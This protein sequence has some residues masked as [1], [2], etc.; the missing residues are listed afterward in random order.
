MH[1]Q[2][3]RNLEEFAMATTKQ[4]QAAKRNIKKAA[5]AALDRRPLP[6]IDAKP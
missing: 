2:Q 3:A 5:A 4:R 6:I 1:N